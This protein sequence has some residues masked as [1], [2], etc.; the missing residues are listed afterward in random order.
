L[1]HSHLEL[2]KTLKSS[3]RRYKYRR[4]EIIR[5]GKN[6]MVRTTDFER[7][8]RGITPHPISSTKISKKAYRNLDDATKGY[9][10][11]V[12]RKKSAGYS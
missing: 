6:I 12:R 2:R 3:V 4:W 9:K 10:E 1:P 5:K 7:L 8:Y 11:L